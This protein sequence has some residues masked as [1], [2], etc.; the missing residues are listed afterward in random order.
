MTAYATT[1]RLITAFT[2]AT[3]LIL[4]VAPAATADPSPDQLSGWE[5][6]STATQPGGQS[7]GES[8]SVPQG[9]TVATSPVADERRG[10]EATG[11]A[12]GT[13]PRGAGDGQPVSTPSPTP[14]ITP[15][16]LY[17]LAVIAAIGLAVGTAR[18]L[19]PHGRS[20]VA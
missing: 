3:L 17:V 10:W 4:A 18:L 20:R 2:L 9:S 14:S 15:T 7:N 5:R 6:T 13:S 1:R 19:R 11:V 12:T 8:A 16:V